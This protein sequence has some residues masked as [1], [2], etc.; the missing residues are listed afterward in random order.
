MITWMLI[1]SAFA[2]PAPAPTSSPSFQGKSSVKVKPAAPIEA[3]VEGVESSPLPYQGKLAPE[4]Q[5]Q[6]G[7]QI[8]LRKGQP[9]RPAP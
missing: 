3:T 2:Q 1:V 6:M 4:A 8:K 7:V 9:K 5:S